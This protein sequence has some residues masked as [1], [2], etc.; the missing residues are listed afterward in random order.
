MPVIQYTRR[1]GGVDR[2]DQRIGCYSVSRRSRRWWLRIF[3]YMLDM[4]V[5][6]AHILHTSVHPDRSMNQLLFRADLFHVLVANFS[7]RGKKARAEINYVQRR[8]H[9]VMTKSPGV[10]ETI[11][12]AAVGIHMPAQQLPGFKRCRACST[13]KKN[14][15]SDPVFNMQSATLRCAVLRVFS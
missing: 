14:T 2:A 11:R 4:A 1:M 10:P 3:Y 5:V 6:N 15:F 8:Q 7:N 12:T 13:K 9:S